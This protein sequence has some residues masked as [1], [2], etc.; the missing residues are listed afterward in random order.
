MELERQLLYDTVAYFENI[1]KSLIINPDSFNISLES[2]GILINA[3]RDGNIQLSIIRDDERSHLWLKDGQ[4]EVR[5]AEDTIQGQT[6][7]PA[8]RIIKY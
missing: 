1:I 3:R 8:Q 2:E 5:F 4:I 6:W 7:L